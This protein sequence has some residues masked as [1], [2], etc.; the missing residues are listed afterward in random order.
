M[1]ILGGLIRIFPPVPPRAATNSR[2]SL[3]LYISLHADLG[4]RLRMRSYCSDTHHQLVFYLGPEGL[5]L[6]CYLTPKEYRLE[7]HRAAVFL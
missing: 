4:T 7:P 5:K 1:R 3:S 6:D 2:V